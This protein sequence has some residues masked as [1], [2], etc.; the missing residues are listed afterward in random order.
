MRTQRIASAPPREVYLAYLD[1]CLTHDM[2]TLGRLMVAAIAPSAATEHLREAF[3][4]ASKFDDVG[5]A[6]III[7]RAHEIHEAGDRHAYPRIDPA[8]PGFTAAVADELRASWV[9]AMGNVQRDIEKMH[10]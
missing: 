8:G 4:W 3:M 5:S 6:S 9:F 7:A 10:N 1:F 2:H